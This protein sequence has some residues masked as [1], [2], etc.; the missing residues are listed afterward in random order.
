ME[1][2]VINSQIFYHGQYVIAAF[3]HDDS[4]EEQIIEDCRLCINDSSSIYLCQ[5]IKDGCEKAKEKFGY[6][7]SWS[8]RIDDEKITSSDTSW[9]KPS[10]SF[11]HDIMPEDW[12]VD[13]K[14][15]DNL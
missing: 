6:K 12:V 10:N 4:D 14:I 3:P 2:V 8:V 5:N 13:E 7:Y 15:P 9:I 11:D 1:T